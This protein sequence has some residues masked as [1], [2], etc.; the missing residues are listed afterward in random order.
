MKEYKLKPNGEWV[1]TQ[2]FTDSIT[3]KDMYYGNVLSI[4]GDWMA[5]GYNYYSSI[6]E[7]DKVLNNAGA[8]HL[9][10]KLN[11]QWLLKQILS[12]ENPVAYNNFGNYVGLKDDILVVGIPG[13]KKPED[14]SMGAISIF[15]RIG[16]IW[17]KIQTIYA[18]A[19]INSLNFGSG[20]VIEG[21][22]IIVTDSKGIHIIENKKDCNGNWR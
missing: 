13:Y 10:Q 1:N 17:T 4:D 6:N 19:A 11:S 9:Y 2:T 3:N 12:E 16:N 14:K 8:V 20:I 7:E 15:K 21:E 5:L 18:D 22:Q